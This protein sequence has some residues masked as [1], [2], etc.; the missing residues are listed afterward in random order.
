MPDGHLS[1][2]TRLITGGRPPHI[3]GASVNTP[4]EFSSTYRA[5]GPIDYARV[6][7]PTWSAFEA[8]LGDLEGGACLAFASGMG[9]IAAACAL[10]GPSA[11]VV[12]PQHSY[13]GTSALLRRREERDGLEVRRVDIS[14]TEAVSAAL[15]GAHLL[16]IESPTNPMM[17]IAD[18]PALASAAREA[19]AIS[20]C[21]NTFATPLLQRPLEAGVDVVVHSATKFL[22]GHSDVLLGATVT[23]RTDLH[24]QLHIHRTLHGA[25][26]G[27][28]ETWLALRGLRTLDVRLERACASAA[29]LADRL[30]AHPR[31]DR[32]RY[33]G[34]GAVLSIE[35]AGGLPAAQALEQG[36]RLWTPATSLGGVESLLERRRRHAAEAD[37]VPEA[38]VRLS[39]GIE[40]VADLWS[41]LEQALENA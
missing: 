23:A 38:L 32:V 3:P 29:T 10:I 25:I 21:D 13:S 30:S 31:V 15:A 22:A 28:M 4:V 16:W 37:T 36:V 6:G 20:V 27:P 8:T 40:A 18:L 34:F 24:E 12:V 14:D 33:P 11:V 1:P 7:N 5:G 39:V 19:G 9:A 26:P 17:E 2:A 41:D 35:I